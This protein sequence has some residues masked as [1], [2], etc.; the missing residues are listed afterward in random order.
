MKKYLI[1]FAVMAMV[2]SCLLGETL[3]TASGEERESV[4]YD[5]YYMNIEIQPGDSLWSIAEQ[6]N[7]NSGM[8]IREYIKEIKQMNHLASDKIKSGDTLA[9][10]YFADTPLSAA[11]V[12]H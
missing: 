10:V 5:R 8:E 6:Y 3:V 2:L 1:I 12:A 9:V 4:I 7:K 11:N